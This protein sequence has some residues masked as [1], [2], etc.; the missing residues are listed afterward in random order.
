M[1]LTPSDPLPSLSQ[2]PGTALVLEKADYSLHQLIVKKKISKEERT[3]IVR[4]LLSALEALHDQRYVHLDVKPANIMLVTDRTSDFAET[5]WKLGDLEASRTSGERVQ[6]LTLCYAPPELASA[7]ID[8]R[9]KPNASPKM[10]IFSAGLTILE[11]VEREPVIKEIPGQRE[12]TLMP[13]ARADNFEQEVRPRLKSITDQHLK[14]VLESMLRF[15]PQE[16]K[17]AADLLGHG[18]FTGQ[19]TT[20]IISAA[21]KEV[22]AEVNRGSNLVLAAISDQHDELLMALEGVED[23]LAKT[24]RAGNEELGHKL[25]GLQ[26]SLL[27]PLQATIEQQMSELTCTQGDGLGV[28][29]HAAVQ[30]ALEEAKAAAAIASQPDV[31]ELM[32]KLDAMAPKSGQDEAALAEQLETLIN[33]MD[34]MNGKIGAVGADVKLV[35]EEQQ[36]QAAMLKRVDTKLDPILSGEVGMAFRYF[37][38]VPKPS[39]DHFGKALR[40]MNPKSWFASPM[41]LVPL[42]FDDKGAAC[43][44]KVKN[45]AGGFDVA[46]PTEFVMKH[47]RLIKLCVLVVKVGVTLGAAQLGAKIPSSSFAALDDVTNSLLTATLMMAEDH[48]GPEEDGDD[49]QPAKKALD[50]LEKPDEAISKLAD[51]GRYKEVSRNEY[52]QLK[53]WMDTK[54]KGWEGKCGLVQKADES[55]KLVYVPDE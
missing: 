50:A 25:N 4:C 17:T 19:V 33:R 7:D 32:A 36:R 9:E 28:E 11:V 16:R 34:E 40:A 42:Y 55:G 45:K 10:D 6:A 8:G 41:L 43:P 1:I 20:S 3:R 52:M 27:E 51:N 47:P 30:S 46:K 49:E 37:M 54:H 14:P 5:T 35:R 29:I 21:N 13:L 44:A 23:R 31:S 39:K 15:S 24:V 53:E 2:S 18:M 12:A 22:V 48:L 38:L 26:R